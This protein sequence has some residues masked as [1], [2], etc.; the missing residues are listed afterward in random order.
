M[1]VLVALDGST[2]GENAAAAIAPWVRAAGA[3]VVLMSVLHPGEIQGITANAGYVYAP[4]PAVM[5]RSPEPPP[6]AL[7]EDRT[8]ALERARVE[9]GEYLAGVAAKA[10][11]GVTCEVQVEWSEQTAEA[12]VRCAQE[13]GANLIAVGTH[14]RSGI[15]RALV[16][17]VA[18]AVVRRSSVPVFL[19]R[20]VEQQA[21]DD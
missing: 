16:G 6:P 17:S 11:P 8:Q 14:G 13:R 12:I 9:T 1:K 3:D 5:S 4:A 19:V 10:L 15:T 21:G 20:G 18:E 7:V 2:F